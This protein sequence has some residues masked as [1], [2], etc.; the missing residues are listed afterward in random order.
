MQD[1]YGSWT[2]VLRELSKESFIQAEATDGSGK[3]I[4]Y[5]MADGLA[6]NIVSQL[7]VADGKI[8]ATCVDIY[9]TEKKD[10]GPG[11]LCRFDPD[12]G[13]WER[14]EKIDGHPVR[15]VTLLQSIGNDLWVGF[16]EG[17]GVAGDSLSYA[18]VVT[19]KLYRPNT[20]SVVLARLSRGEWKA[21][22]RAPM[23]SQPSEP[24]QR[25]HTFIDELS[26][27]VPRKITPSGQGVMLLSSAEAPNAGYELLW[28]SPAF[29]AQ[30][31]QR[32][33]A[34]VRRC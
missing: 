16:R 29:P 23:T 33:M 21:F 25:K 11:G 17:G 22:S 3:V 34:R 14:I 7:A 28:I 6:G 30:S 9:D 8:W 26:G 27:E 20:T 5:T 18:K 19:A 10:W 31:G 4:R 2:A 13:R 12:T 32:E 15:W 1:T 24:P